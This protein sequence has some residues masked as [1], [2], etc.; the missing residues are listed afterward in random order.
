MGKE[1]EKVKPT[2]AELE[3][4][5]GTPNEMDILPDGSVEP[6]YGKPRSEEDLKAALRV[7][8]VTIVK[9]ILKVPPELALQLP[10]IHAVLKSA[11]ACVISCNKS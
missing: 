1:P 3:A 4:A 9:D 11:L 6:K 2:I 7:V 5:I 8:E 10:T